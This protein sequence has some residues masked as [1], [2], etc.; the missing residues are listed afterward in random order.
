MITF[1]E[2]EPPDNRRDFRGQMIDRGEFDRELL[3]QARKNGADCRF[4]SILRSIDADG[5]V[6]LSSG[7]LVSPKV[8][9]GAD[10][11]RSI[12]GRTIGSSSRALVDTRQITVPL[13]TPHQG[14]DIF[15]SAE[16]VGGYGWMFPK[17]EVANIGPS[18][19]QVPGPGL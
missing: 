3:S 4:G 10:G 6:L 14:T 13:L 17:G 11:P 7:E 2:D 1:V 9:I 19:P 18:C 5:K 15:L 8:I 16:I 12:V